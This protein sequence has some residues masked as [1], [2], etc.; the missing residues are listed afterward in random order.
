MRGLIT[1]AVVALGAAA[2][3]AQAADVSIANYSFMP[4]SITIAQG[5]TVKWTWAGPD[6]N[7]SVT[8]GSGQADSWDSD[9]SGTALTINHPKGDTFSHTF[10]TTG[11]FTYFCKVHSYMTGKVMVVLPGSGPPPDTTAPKLS[12]VSATG[13]RKCKK[14]QKN[15]KGKQTV[16]RFNLSEPATVKVRVPKHKAANVTR[17]LKAGSNTIK[18]S[19]GKLPP[20]KWT[21]KL[22]ASDSSGNTSPVKPVTVKVKK[23]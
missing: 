13:G 9:P 22:S 6:T 4:S 18:F 5:D 1:A 15:C 21:L 14:G 16:L 7:H 3:P 12:K 23:G 19:T 20:G 17:S 2:A 11:T 10:N 8:A